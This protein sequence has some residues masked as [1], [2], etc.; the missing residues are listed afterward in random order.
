[1]N[2]ETFKKLKMGDIV[3]HV[4]NSTMI[5]VVTG[6]YGDRVTAINSYDITDPDEWILFINNKHN[7]LPMT[8]KQILEWFYERLHYIYMENENSD[9]MLRLRQIIDNWKQD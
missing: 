7:K 4:L 8:D 5:G 2:K 1:M 9:Y 6:N 3:K